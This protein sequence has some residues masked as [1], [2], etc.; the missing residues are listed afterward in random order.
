MQKE[1]WFWRQEAGF[2]FRCCHCYSDTTQVTCPLWASSA[3]REV[4]MKSLLPEALSLPGSLLDMWDPGR[5]LQNRVCIHM[6][7]D[8]WKVLKHPSWSLLKIFV[9]VVSENRGRAEPKWTKSLT[10]LICQDRGNEGEATKGGSPLGNRPQP[11]PIA[12]IGADLCVLSGC[13][14]LM[15]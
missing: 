12:Q 7:S 8:I 10:G 15:S 13:V 5:P 6:H 3:E 9:N 14:S 1:H 4:L 2:W 11:N